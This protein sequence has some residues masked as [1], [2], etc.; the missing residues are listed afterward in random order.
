[1]PVTPELHE[2][3]T[4]L[5]SELLHGPPSH[6][7]YVLNRGDPGLLRSLD[8]LSAQGASASPASGAAPIAAHVDHL[9]Y[10]LE[11]MTRW[12][13]GEPNPWA[14]ADWGASWRRRKVNEA[15][16]LGL[17][18]RLRTAAAE[19]L[20]SLDTSRELSDVA[21]TA[22]I[23]GIVHLAYHLGSIRQIDRSIRGPA[24]E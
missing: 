6:S 10:G 17:R 16:W 5:L 15:E 2:S 18:H 13:R 8:K 12:N 7:A 24:A 20:E 22:M 3:L 14:R 21:R 4:T 23:S 1:M 19:Y 9:C 11:L